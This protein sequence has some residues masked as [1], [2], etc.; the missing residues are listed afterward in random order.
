MPAALEKRVQALMA[1]GMA[2]GRAYAIATK[3]LQQAGVMKK[4]K[5]SSRVRRQ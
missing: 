3:Q 4:G 2:K 1:G 5:T